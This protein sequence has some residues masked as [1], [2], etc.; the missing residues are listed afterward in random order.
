MIKYDKS[1]REKGDTKI[2]QLQLVLMEMLKAIDAICRK[3]DIKYW[4]DAGN[5]L[6]HVRHGGFIPW[7]DDVDLGMSREDYLK[8]I[9]VA[10]KELPRDLFFQY[11]KSDSKNSKWIRIRD[12]YST[13]VMDYEIGQEPKYHQ[14]IFIDIFP[15]DILEKD[16]FNAKIFLNRKYQ[17]SK[18]PILK[19]LRWFFNQG[20][21]IPVKLI[22]VHR[23][24]RNILKKYTGPNPKLV[25]IGIEIP[26]FYYSYKY[27]TVFPLKDIDYL[28][29]KVLAPNNIETYLTDM[30]GDYMTIPEEKDRKIH[31]HKILPFKKCNHPAALD[32]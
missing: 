16:F 21:T 15:F 27:S 23:L 8:F 10:P 1:V 9:E 30:Y 20:A 13:V 19:K 5:L 7:D 31:A 4:L 12:N 32:Y 6:G 17:R 14:G 11:L 2:A 3:H 29:L 24:K 22:G 28:G 26:N 25:S 18:N